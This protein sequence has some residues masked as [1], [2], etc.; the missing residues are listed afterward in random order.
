MT[1]AN[2]PPTLIKSG[3]YMSKYEITVDGIAYAYSKKTKCGGI[4]GISVTGTG[5]S[6][7]GL[8]WNSKRW[9]KVESAIR[10]RES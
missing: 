2:T 3:D 8:K 4:S 1:T 10:A 9:Q 7:G 6:R 5:N